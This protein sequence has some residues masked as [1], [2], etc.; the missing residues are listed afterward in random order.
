MKALTT[1]NRPRFEEGND[2]HQSGQQQLAD[3]T[4]TKYDQEIASPTAIDQPF[5]DTTVVRQ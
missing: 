5:A 4:G 3:Y 1:K 2:E